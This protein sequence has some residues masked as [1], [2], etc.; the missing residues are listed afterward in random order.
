MSSLLNPGICF[1]DG[2]DDAAGNGSQ[3]PN[4]YNNYGAFPL[5]QHGTENASGMLYPGT[6]FTD[7]SNGAAGNGPQNGNPYCVYQ[8]PQNV[9]VL[10]LEQ[11]ATL[12]HANM[13]KEMEFQYRE[14]VEQMR[15]HYLEEERRREDERRVRNAAAKAI[16]QQRQREAIE[17]LKIKRKLAQVAVTVDSSGRFII[18]FALP[19]GPVKYSKPVLSVPNMQMRILRCATRRELLEMISWGDETTYLLLR[20]PS[21]PKDFHLGLKRKGLALGVSKDLLNTVAD[22]I[23]CRLKLHAVEE[24]IPSVFGW[25]HM[26]DGSWCFANNEERTF[27]FLYKE[28]CN[29]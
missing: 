1:S 25:N 15:L 4:P 7:G 18:E 10:S 5:A 8:Y 16:I 19:D 13:L 26:S 27:D 12:L 3:Q 24:E 6:I 23:Y 28:A 22:L 14:K 21:N 11:Q 9:P 2:S 20:E 29:G 17:D